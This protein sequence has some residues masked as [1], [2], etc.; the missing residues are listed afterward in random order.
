MSTISAEEWATM[1]PPDRRREIGNMTQSQAA[2]LYA[3]L[4]SDQNKGP[5]LNRSEWS[6][7][8]HTGQEELLDLLPEW[9]SSILRSW[10]VA[11]SCLMQSLGASSH[12]QE[13]DVEAWPKKLMYVLLFWSCIIPPFGLILCIFNFWK[14]ARLAQSVAMLT[15]GALMFCLG[16]P[17][18]YSLFTTVSAH[19]SR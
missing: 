1:S 7:L 14:P 11:E 16:Y 2:E 18:L 19:L 8:G 12:K 13:A 3:S 17:A 10:G 15:A 9:E 4:P 5:R 6:A